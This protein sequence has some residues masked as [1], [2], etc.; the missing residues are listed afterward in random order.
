MRDSDINLH[1]V[2]DSEHIIDLRFRTYE[3]DAQDALYSE[4]GVRLQ[5][6]QI[7][8]QDIE[9]YCGYQITGPCIP[10]ATGGDELYI[11]FGDTSP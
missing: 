3:D 10:S 11:E 9:G 1:A 7:Q 2:R 5:I 6:D 8:R 4:H